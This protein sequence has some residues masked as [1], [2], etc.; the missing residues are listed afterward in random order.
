MFWVGEDRKEKAGTQPIAVSGHK[1]VFL[2]IFFK[3][4]CEVP[5][6]EGEGRSISVAIWASPSFPLTLSS[7]FPGILAILR[8]GVLAE[9]CGCSRI[10]R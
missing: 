8:M 6:E 10:P 2:I 9:A 5:S 3:S 1:Q 4:D 7:M